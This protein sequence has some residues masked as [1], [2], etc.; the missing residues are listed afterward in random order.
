MTRPKPPWPIQKGKIFPQ[1][2]HILPSSRGGG[3]GF[4]NILN[5][6]PSDDHWVWHKLFGNLTP[7]EIMTVL[8]K[9]LFKGGAYRKYRRSIE[10]NASK[11]PSMSPD[12][13]I[14]ALERQVFP[15]NWA[16]SDKLMRR[17]ERLRVS[18]KRAA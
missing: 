12:E 11:P 3:N 6:I 10:K 16:P 9:H 2:H 7:M 8:V 5:G 17:L 1:K 14:L 13:I 18:R 4:R 15:K